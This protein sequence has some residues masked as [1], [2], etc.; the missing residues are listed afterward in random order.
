VTLTSAPRLPAVSPARDVQR[1]GV[2]DTIRV[3]AMVVAPT[4]AAGVVK[5][6]PWLMRVTERLGLDRRAIATMRRLRDR[7]G[8]APVALRV[9]GRSFVFPLS[10]VDA[11]RVLAGTPDPFSPAT[12]EKRAALRHFQPHAVLISR[13]AERA[14]RRAFTETVLQPANEMHS[15]A[16]RVV[17]V[18]RAESPGGGELTWD[19][20]NR[21]WWRIV[22]RIV[23]GDSARD[24]EELT[25]LLDTLRAAG[26]WAYLRP[27]R[28]RDRDR[29][30]ARLA[31]RVRRPEFGSLAAHVAATRA[32]ADVDPVGQIPHW[33]FA[34]DAAGMATFR[35]M[36]LL[37]RH[38]DL[39]D[40]VR[41]DL[42]GFDLTRPQPLPYLRACV[43]DTVR[44]WPTT[45]ALLRETVRDTGWGPAGTTAFLYTPFFH[46]D[47]VALPSADRFAPEE[48]LDGTAAAHPALVPFS[49]GPGE[50]PGRNIVL[51]TTSTMLA[52]IVA[53]HDLCLHGTHGIHPPA[54]LPATLDNFSVRLRLT[55]R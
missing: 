3:L 2:V 40:A 22:R 54:P 25:R 39:L 27:R 30:L 12:T 38:R 49:A 35:T 52:T 45:P 1:L 19:E 7:H 21:H 11:G 4:L 26:N 43:L 31:D 44:L 34:F 42:D 9:P 29:F 8:P 50:C 47:P 15:L 53:G 5:R 20:F 32:P 37:A 6:R 41:I 17:D 24:D 18:V 16:P 10:E 14:D 51:L 36:A 48:W 46:R 13:G 23:L 55:P 28:R 33:L